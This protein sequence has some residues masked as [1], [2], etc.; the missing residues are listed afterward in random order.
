ME[1]DLA[2]ASFSGMEGGNLSAAVW[3]C[4]VVPPFSGMPLEFAL[5][6]QHRP[7]SWDSWYRRQHAEILPRLQTQFR[8]A[9]VLAA[10]R[11]ATLPPGRPPVSAQEYFDRYLYAAH[12]NEF[13]LSLFPLPTHP[14]GKRPWTHIFGGHPTMGSKSKYERIC[15]DGGRFPFIRGLRE[16]HRPKVI[17]CLGQRQR[18]DY[19]RAFGFDNVPP[20]EA[21]L[22]PADIPARLMVYEQAGTTLIVSPP[23]AGCQGL[24]SDTLLEA[25]GGFVAKWL[26]AEDFRTTLAIATPQALPSAVD[27]PGQSSEP[28]ASAFAAG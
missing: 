23:F 20:T 10:A 26:R 11:E 16:L 6:A 19:L 3:V 12:G 27:S 15:R 9:R 4:D 28:A 7:A 25:L 21:I 5:Q 22:Q 24:C 8:I 13:K 17:L 14:D 18:E 1:L 2:F